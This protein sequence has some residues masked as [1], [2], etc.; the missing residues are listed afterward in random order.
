MCVCGY[1]VGIFMC[2]CVGGVGGYVSIFIC[3]IVMWVCMR[4]K[5]ST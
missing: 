5:C 1:Y 4:A 2:M 3:V